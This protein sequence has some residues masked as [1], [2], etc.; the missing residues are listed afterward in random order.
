MSRELL[1]SPLHEL[2]SRLARREISSEELVR[3]AI[4]RTEAIE[5]DLHSYITFIPERALESARERDRARARGDATGP[6]HGIPIT[7]KDVFDTSGI[8]TTAGARFL[9][10]NVPEEDA[11]VARRLDEAGAV[12]LGKANLNKFAG[13][14]SGAN[15]DFG[16]MHNPWNL[17]YSPSGSS[18]GSASQVAAGLAALSVGSDNGGSV[19]NPASVCNVVG[20][21][22]THGRISTE[23][24]FPRAYSIDHV[25]TLTR[26]V[27]D[28]AIAMSVLAGHRAGDAT[29][30]RYDVPDYVDALERPVA[31]VRVGVDRSLL[32]LAQPAVT[33][34]F[35]RAI[36]TLSELSMEIVDIDFP[37]PEEMSEAMYLIFLCEWAAAHEPW[38]RERPQEY[39]GGA[40]GALLISATDYLKAQRER[41]VLQ[42]RA[43]EAL[44]PVDLIA[45]PTYPIVRRSHRGLPRIA[46]RQIDSMEVLRFTMPY[47]LLGLPAISVPAGFEGDDAPIGFQLAGRAFDEAGVL[48]AAYAYERATEWHSKHP[49]I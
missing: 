23:G 39:G 46:G 43:A 30:A 19:R 44:R 10:D 34:T 21:K 47:D 42:A 40:R 1:L 41:R 4:E 22:P 25:G 24:M 17:D 8:R 13:G 38:M 36:A 48:R 2:A 27:K 29:T 45:T 32:R 6:L 20:L 12:L 16:N 5:P 15:P 49:D 35:E 7:L 28:A 26:T 11:D 18:G 3:L 33:R 14:E 9:L 31:G 37:S